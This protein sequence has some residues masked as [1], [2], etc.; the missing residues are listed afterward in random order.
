M[1]EESCANCKHSNILQNKENKI[2][3]VCVPKSNL[4]NGKYVKVEHWFRCSFFKEDD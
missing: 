1:K 2:V 3:F 4:W